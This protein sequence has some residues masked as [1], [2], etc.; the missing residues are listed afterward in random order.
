VPILAKQLGATDVTQSML[1]TMHIGV[2][3]IG[4][5]MTT[6]LVSRIGAKRLVFLSFGLY[7]I[8]IGLAAYAPTLTVLFVAQLCMGLA[9]GV[10]Y[11]VLMGLSI[12]YV[13]DSQRTIAMGLHQSVY[14]IGMFVGPWLSGLIADAIGLQ[15]MLGGP[16]LSVLP[17]AG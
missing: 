2:V 6:F 13:V 1:V 9:Q 8:G 12:K 17:W 7:S 14:A 3:I 4:N 10:S 15:P 11:P 5:L 16:P